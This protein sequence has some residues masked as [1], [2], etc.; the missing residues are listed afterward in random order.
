MISLEII[1]NSNF[2]LNFK[3]TEDE[4]KKLLKDFSDNFTQAHML[5]KWIED[6]DVKITERLEYFAHMWFIFES[7]SRILKLLTEAG[8]SE[9]QI[10][11]AL[12]EIPF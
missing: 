7:M 9:K 10:I 11:E 2:S 3:L 8:L 4:T 1:I 12:N 5:M 6:P